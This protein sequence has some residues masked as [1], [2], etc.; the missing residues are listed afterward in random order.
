M[1]SS[2]LFQRELDGPLIGP[3]ILSADFSNLGAQV[4]SVLRAG[5]DYIHVDV[6]D[7]HFVP[8]LSMGPAVCAA[9]R[10]SAP[11]A[12]IDVHLMVTDPGD[13]IDPFVEAGADHISFHVEARGSASR[14]LDRIHAAGLTAGIA[15]RP[16]TKWE[17]V[18]SHF[19]RADVFLVM[20]V[21]PG[22]GGQKFLRSA[23]PKVRALRSRISA[24]QRIE[25]DG[26]INAATAKACVAAGGDA[27]VAGN[28]VFGAPDPA[29]AIRA[30][31]VKRSALGSP[32][33]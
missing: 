22:F 18:A 7:G 31:R 28:F 20:S 21:H 25:L 17:A 9:V 14:L 29:S 27:L 30:L 26:G 2:P 12:W 32:R 6:M 3:S 16:E 24:T 8:N 13:F 23:L 1:T 10:R 5:A 19:A 11:K 33:G 4:R 15:I